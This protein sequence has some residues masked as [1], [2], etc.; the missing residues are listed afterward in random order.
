MK[1]NQIHTFTDEGKFT[2][3]AIQQKD[4]ALI[5]AEDLARCLGYAPLDTLLQRVDTSVRHTT[6]LRISKSRFVEASMVTMFGAFS[7]IMESRSPDTMKVL[8]WFCQHVLPTIRVW[9]TPHVLDDTKNSHIGDVLRKAAK[10][11]QGTFSIDFCSALQDAFSIP[12]GSPRLKQQLEGLIR[13][14]VYDGFIAIQSEDVRARCEELSDNQTKLHAFILK[15]LQRRFQEHL[16]HVEY[17][18]LACAGSELE[19]RD[20]FEHYCLGRQQMKLGF[21][22]P[23]KQ[24]PEPDDRYID[25][26]PACT[27]EVW[28]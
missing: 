24:P 13:T 25:V 9:N 5:S 18:A 17:L 21:D 6:R 14:F 22:T 4:C 19:F 12:I 8:V 2:L 27:S 15:N 23:R 11:W 3:R 7:L 28:G 16:S 26:V 1:P 10:H 20:A